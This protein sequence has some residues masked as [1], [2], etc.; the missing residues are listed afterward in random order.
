V[1]IP[2]QSVLD[3][4]DA[5]AGGRR[6]LQLLVVDDD[7]TQRM[8]ISSAARQAGHAVTVAKSCAEAI[9]Q[10]RIAQFDCVTLDLMLGDGDG[11]EV[12]QAMA[13]EKFTGSVIVIS[14]MNAARRIAARAYARSLGIELQSLP[15]PVDL[16]ALRICLANLCKTA[17][18]LP[19]M[20]TWGGVEVD[21]VAEQHRT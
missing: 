18:G 7:A 4:P 17:M 16:A 19:V 21:G 14:G 20:H 12:L 5:P 9:Q 6:S 13:A 2:S 8:L 11:I 1:S 10:V 3:L 15:K